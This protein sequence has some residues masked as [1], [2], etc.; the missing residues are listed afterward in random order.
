M[1]QI[2]VHMILAS[3]PEKTWTEILPELKALNLN[4]TSLD[5]IAKNIKSPQPL[6]TLLNQLNRDFALPL[7]AQC[8]KIAQL[9]NQITPAEQK[10][11]EAIASKK[12]EL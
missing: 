5:A 8:K 10:I 1:D 2:L 11:I 4:P 7:L 6:E 12:V 9:D 3:H